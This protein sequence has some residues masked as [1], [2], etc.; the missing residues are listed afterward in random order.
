MEKGSESLIVDCPYCNEEVDVDDS[1]LEYLNNE[2]YIEDYE[3]D[4]CGREFDIYVEFDPVCSAEEI[5]YYKCDCCKRED[6]IRN[7]YKRG[8]TFPFPKCKNF[9]VLCHN[10]YSEQM[11]L[12]W[13]REGETVNE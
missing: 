1:N 6:K 8:R 7:F 13:K 4:H 10:C 5:E 2:N 12:E 11:G 9:D 3:C